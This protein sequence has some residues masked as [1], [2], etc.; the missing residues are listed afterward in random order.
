MFFYAKGKDVE[1]ENGKTI[2]SG[3]MSVKQ[4][5]IDVGLVCKYILSEAY[6]KE[7]TDFI[8][9]KLGITTSSV[10]EL[11]SAYSSFHDIGKIHPY[12]QMYFSESVEN[13]K[14]NN[15]ISDKFIERYNAERKRYI[16]RHEVI[17]RLVLKDELRSILENLDMS[18]GSEVFFESLTYVLSSHHEKDTFIENRIPSEK[19]NSFK[20]S[21]KEL[22]DE[23]L[24]IFPINFE[25]YRNINR[26]SVDICCEVFLGTLVLSDWVA[27]SD[28]MA[29]YI[30]DF[31]TYDKNNNLNEYIRLRTI[32]IK[33]I[34]KE[35]LGLLKDKYIDFSSFS[36][37]FGTSKYSLR[38]V[39]KKIE[40]VCKN[41]DNKFVLIEAPMG[42]GKTE[43][44][45]YAAGN[46]AYGK[47]GVFVALPTG[48]TS[49]MMYERLEDIFENQGIVDLNLMYAISYLEDKLYHSGMDDKYNLFSKSRTGMFISNGV[50]TVDQAMMAVLK[51]KFSVLRLLGLMGKVLVVDEVHAYD[52]YM[53]GIICVLLNWCNHLEIPVVLLSATLPKCTRKK[54]IEAFMD[55]EVEL[56]EDSYPLITT[57]NV[58]NELNEYSVDSSYMKKE[59]DFNLI[60]LDE[61]YSSFYDSVSKEVKK[62]Q[63]IGIVCNT[64]KESQKLYDMLKDISGYEVIL[65]HSGFKIKDRTNKEDVLKAKL[66]KKNIE[67]RKNLKLLVIGTQVLEQS[68]D[69]DFDVL[70][71]YL[72]PIDL[73]LQ[74]IGRWRRFDIKDRADDTTVYVVLNS[75]EIN[76]KS[77]L[78][79]PF[80]FPYHISVMKLT[81]KYLLNNSHCSLPND[82]RKCISFVYDDL[83][84]S[85]ESVIE[86]EIIDGTNEK[87]GKSGAKNKPNLKKYH[88]S[89][90]NSES[91]S[92]SEEVFDD[93]ATT[94][95]GIP[96]KK[97][98]LMSEKELSDIGVSLENLKICDKELA[99]SMIEHSVSV[100]LYHSGTVEDNPNTIYELGGILKGFNLVVSNDNNGVYKATVIHKET[101]DGN[102]KEN[103]RSYTY[104]YTYSREY[105]LIIT[106]I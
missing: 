46:M 14:C 97:I 60:R 9:R 18:K 80:E 10:I 70:F 21:Q 84:F 17:T 49:K 73:L 4:H 67:N 90:A 42:E 40:E 19:F 6:N 66:G 79:K 75:V 64:I 13:M 83:D 2:V 61:N 65:L 25:N 20:E 41:K 22:L 47:K 3:T 78:D 86:K 72:C 101:V 103:I 76:D 23:L 68:L 5:C 48:V 87:L 93:F 1:K 105:G 71:S 32:Q 29:N 99:K 53:S 24:T 88:R 81:E 15:V 43:A 98:I 50:G 62:G 91:I 95:L 52:A 58:N 28:Y 74:R 77:D 12:F 37:I 85:D 69:I 92:D 106:K 27:S 104:E 36:S 7:V 44:G 39:Q 63:N 30:I 45:L 57:V 100:K 33:K 16:I 34:F 89:S 11:L 94:R 59:I 26:D 82:F 55:R 8:A 31:N 56:K 38:P 96:Q 102:K 51:T 54:Y 35:N